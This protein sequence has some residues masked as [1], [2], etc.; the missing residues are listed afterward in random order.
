MK[1]F[2]AVRLIV[3]L[4]VG[5][6]GPPAA[7]QG[8]P[9]DAEAPPALA[10]LA[11]PAPI[12]AAPSASADTRP[13]RGPAVRERGGR[14]TRAGSSATGFLMLVILVGLMGYDVVKK[15]RRY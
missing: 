6:G 5:L 12:G 9:V 10:P 7:A 8:G 14:R 4:V 2:R 3:A 13:A 11:P 15:I 1:R